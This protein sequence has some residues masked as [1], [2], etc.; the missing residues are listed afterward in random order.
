M[1]SAADELRDGASASNLDAEDCVSIDARMEAVRG[2]RLF[3]EDQ[4]HLRGAPHLCEDAA[5]VTAELLANAVQHAEPPIIVCVSNHEGRIR[6]GV[7]DGSTRLPVRPAPSATNMTGR[8][9]ALVE[10]LV[11]RWGVE[12][13]R[14]RPGKTVWAEFDPALDPVEIVDVDVA[15]VDIEELLADWEDDY[16]LAPELRYTV[17]LGDV[18]TDLLIEAKAHIDNV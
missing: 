3:V 7:Q 9:L 17:V 12:R 1:D 5:L 13:R 14:D 18:P 6:V 15:P 16:Q 11:H 4:V 8:G 10:A 2:G